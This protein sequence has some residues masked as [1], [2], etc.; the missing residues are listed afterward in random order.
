MPHL[1]VEQKGSQ[2]RITEVPDG[3]IEEVQ[4]LLNGTRFQGLLSRLDPYGNSSYAGEELVWLSAALTEVLR[5]G[6]QFDKE[7]RS[8]LDE[9]VFSKKRGLIVFFS[10]D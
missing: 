2:P 5:L 4:A 6:S 7:T 1:V 8:L 10:G 9:I 3:W